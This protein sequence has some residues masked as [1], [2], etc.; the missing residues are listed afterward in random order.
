MKCFTRYSF[1]KPG[2]Y[3]VHYIHGVAKYEGMTKMT[4]AGV[5]RD[6]L[7][8]AYKGTDKLYLPS[9]QIDAVRHYVGGETPTLNRLGGGDFAKAKAKVRSAVRA[10]AQ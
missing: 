2:N 1:L 4:V 8:L 3:V 6:Y 7:V 5:E 10:I 9:D